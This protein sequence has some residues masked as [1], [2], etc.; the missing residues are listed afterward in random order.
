MALLPAD[1][2][3]RRLFALRRVLACRA[4]THA[5]STCPPNRVAW[6]RPV[7]ILRAVDARALERPVRAV[8]DWLCSRSMSGNCSMPTSLHRAARDKAAQAG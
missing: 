3:R 6:S 7:G 5:T 4:L 8:A 2:P 1:D